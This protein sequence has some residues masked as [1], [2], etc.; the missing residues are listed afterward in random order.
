VCV[1]DSIDLTMD[2]LNLSFFKIFL[3][4]VREA[5]ETALNKNKKNVRE[6][7]IFF[8]IFFF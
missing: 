4:V 6:L 5:I 8:F 3:G 7:F 1:L 2:I